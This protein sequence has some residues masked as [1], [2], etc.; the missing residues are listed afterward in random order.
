MNIIQAIKN[1]SRIVRDEHAPMDKR[2]VHLCWLLHLGGDS[3]QPLHA[4]T[5]VTARRF[6]EGDHGGNFLFIQR[7]W[8]L[9]AFWDDQVSNDDDFGVQTRLVE[10]LVQNAE[11]SAAGKKAAASLDPGVWID[12]SHDIGVKF[13]Y[14]PELI[15]KVAAREGHT[16]LGPLDL[17]D[18]YKADAERLSER[19]A[20]EPTAPS[21]WS[22]RCATGRLRRVAADGLG[23]PGRPGPAACCRWR[24]AGACSPSSSQTTPV[25]A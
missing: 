22:A 6:P 5:L 18:R 1:S 4:V 7:D 11:L 20:A 10:G 17:S 8:K 21:P 23:R 19:R 13:A 15:K 25:M 16:H 2:A 12:E 14:T 24:P 9:H 3:H